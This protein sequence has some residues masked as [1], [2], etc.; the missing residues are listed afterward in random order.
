MGIFF[1][2]LWWRRGAQNDKGAGGKE[3]YDR[4]R[5]LPVMLGLVDPFEDQGKTNQE[6]GH[7]LSY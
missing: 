6:M 4:E 5:I 7:F 3:K 1:S 2:I